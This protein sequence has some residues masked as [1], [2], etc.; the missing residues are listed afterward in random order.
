M[1][2]LAFQRVF[3]FDGGFGAGALPEFQGLNQSGLTAGNFRHMA[4]G[5]EN[6]I[7]HHNAYYP[8]HT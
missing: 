6:V 8:L 1:H 2:P 5:M 4:L 7:A 3:S